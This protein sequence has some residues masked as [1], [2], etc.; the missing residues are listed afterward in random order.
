MEKQIGSPEDRTERPTPAW[1][2]RTEGRAE[3]PTGMWE[4]WRKDQQVH[5]R[6]G[7]RCQ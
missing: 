5:G 6:T 2:N 4:D 1:G 7:Q 3:R